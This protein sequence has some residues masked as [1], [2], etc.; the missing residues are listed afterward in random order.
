MNLRAMQV[1]AAERLMTRPLVLSIL[2]GTIRRSAYAR[3]LQDVYW[4]ASHS[5][6]VIA[7]AGTRLVLS[8]PVMAQY[9]F[10][11]AAEELGHDRWAHSDLIDLGL[12][13]A[14]IEGSAPSSACLHMIG[15]E[16]LYASHL[17][18]IGVFGWMFV[19][20]S[21]GAKVG[22]HI[23][24]GLDSALQLH[25]KALQFLTGHAEAD[26]HHAE[27]LHRVIGDQLRTA[28]DHESFE[29]M[30][31]ESLESYCAILESANAVN[32][33]AA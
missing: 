13:A 3:Y 18:P 32:Q 2:E 17:N 1:M 4:Y 9:L 25:G 20:E 15:L 28:D 22:G 29:R 31:G 14:Q 16:Y 10:T 12:S 7:L 26:I 33:S 6:Q 19:L 24:S 30:F 27:D 21:L 5:A 11:H 23:A 8:H